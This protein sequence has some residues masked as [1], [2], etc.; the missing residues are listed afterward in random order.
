MRHTILGFMI[1]AIIAMLVLAPKL[2]QAQ[3][4][5]PEWYSWEYDE[6]IYL[7]HDV[8][9]HLYLAHEDFERNDMGHAAE[10]I[11]TAADYMKLEAGRAVNK[12]EKEALIASIQELEQLANGVVTGKVRSVDELN[13]AFAH[14]DYVLATHHLWQAQE[15]MKKSEPGAAN[16][17]LK[18]SSF[19]L[20]R[21]M[22]YSSTPAP[23]A[24]AAPTKAEAQPLPKP[25]YPAVEDKVSATIALDL[26]YHFN[27]ALEDFREKD[28]KGS[29]QEIRTIIALLKLEGS[30]T[31]GEAQKAIVKS[32]G[33]LDTVAVA[34]EKGAGTITSEQLASTFAR[35]DLILAKRD[36]NMAAE[37]WRNKELQDVGYS[38]HASAILLA[39][40]AELYGKKDEKSVINVVR[41][42]EPVADEL[43]KGNQ[44]PAADV[45]KIIKNGTKAVDKLSKF[46]ASMK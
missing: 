40:A 33:E 20:E 16:K 11:L 18:A 14:A 28:M 7:T 24:T 46:E 19:H 15:A 5:Y 6:G 32:I 10:Q 23:P 12:E 13:T 21:S 31:T 22:G 36:Y 4:E 8:D 27:L 37:D 25:G 43:I 38:L 9:H 35:V 42:T 17:E 30:R 2:A 45:R 44:A 34:A 41:E 26:T 1:A 29:A 3:Q 39:N